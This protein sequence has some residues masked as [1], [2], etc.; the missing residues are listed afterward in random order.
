MPLD[1][2]GNDGSQ[3]IHFA[4]S[5]G[6]LSIIQWLHERGVPLDVIGDGLQPIDFAVS[7]WQQAV[8]KWLRECG[9]VP[10]A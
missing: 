8:V 6:H 1:V 5:N 3:A 2:A 10:G 4:A 9:C 7:N